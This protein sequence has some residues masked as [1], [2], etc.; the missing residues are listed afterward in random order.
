MSSFLFSF[1][2]FILLLLPLVVFHELGHFLFAKL[3]DVRAEVFSVGFGPK[4]LKKKWGET[5]FCLSLIPLGGYVKLL[6]EDAQAAL[7]PEEKPYA[8]NYQA[9]W[10]RFLIVFG[11]PLFNFILAW[12]IFVGIYMMG[13]PLLQATIGR[14]FPR[15]LAYQMGFRIGDTI[16]EADGKSIEVLSDLEPI[17]LNHPGKTLF[18]KVIPSGATFPKTLSILLGAQPGSSMYGEPQLVGEISGVSFFSR[19]TRFGISSPKSMA[20]HLGFPRAGRVLSWNQ[21][22]V[23]SWEELEQKYEE[24]PVGSEIT[25]EVQALES[26]SP[27]TP[28]Q[29]GILSSHTLK[30]AQENLSLSQEWGLHS[31]ELFVEAVLP[32]SPALHAGIQRGDRITY[33]GPYSLGAFSEMKQRIQ[34]QGEL[35]RPIEIFLERDGKSVMTELVPKATPIKSTKLER[36]KQYTIGIQPALEYAP[37][38]YHIKQTFHPSE[39]AVL[40]ASRVGDLIAKNLISIKKMLFRDIST[41]GLGGPLSIGKMAGQALEKGLLT[42]LNGMAVFSVGL[43][44]LNILP[45]P[46]LDGGQLVLLAIE[47]FRKKSLSAR[48]IEVIQIV[49]FAVI[50]LLMLIAFSND[51]MRLLDGSVH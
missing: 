7:S 35:R 28:S 46:V 38:L 50:V 11:G 27:H 30:K 10:K 15:S 37:P 12:L 33:I 19:S 43:G 32:D 49:G 36:S 41:E 24:S 3:F 8:M 2:A 39:L 34:E 21:T 4:L 16:I 31:S 45:I 51:L 1:L 44:V 22:K 26:L 5:E 18:F 17:I 29:A 20:A 23:S 25:L 48:Q 40:S 42:F 14:V 6:G 47:G 9:G 13:E